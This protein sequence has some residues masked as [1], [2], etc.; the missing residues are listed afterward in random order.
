MVKTKVCI[1]E[2]EVKALVLGSDC[3]VS[4]EVMLESARRCCE[5]M[6]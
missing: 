5:T 2:L 6:E 4:E 3:I 1:Y